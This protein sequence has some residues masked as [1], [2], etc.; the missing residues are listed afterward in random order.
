MVLSLEPLTAT[1]RTAIVIT[2]GKEGS[3]DLECL[4]WRF[5]ALRGRRDVWGMS[6]NHLG[7]NKNLEFWNFFFAPNIFSKS[8]FSLI[9]RPKSLR[10]Q[11]ILTVS[12]H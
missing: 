10:R 4:W 2:R 3:G 7:K 6:E 11:A 1:P 9:L 8:E 12:T 5:G